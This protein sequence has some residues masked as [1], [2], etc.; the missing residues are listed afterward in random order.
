M[1]LI[2][3]GL[4]LG[5]IVGVLGMGVFDV[6]FVGRYVVTLSLL[7]VNLLGVGFALFLTAMLYCV[8]FL[9]EK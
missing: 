7:W 6:L 8:V 3:R 2:L 9:E 1:K 4:R 5:L